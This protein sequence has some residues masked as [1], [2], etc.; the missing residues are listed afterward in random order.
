MTGSGSGVA[1]WKGVRLLVLMLVP[2]VLIGVFLASRVAPGPNGG[3]GLGRSG[4]IGARFLFSIGEGL[5][6][7]LAVALSPGAVYV[8]D[9]GHGSIKVF[10][11][12]GAYLRDV[13]IQ[14]EGKDTLPPYPVGL[15]VDAA[16]KL[17]VSDLNGA[18]ILR[19]SLVEGKSEVFLRRGES[20]PLV[21]PVGVLY[22]GGLI[23]VNDVGLGQVLVFNE[24]GTLE[25]VFGFGK[26]TGVGYM[27]YPNFSWLDK[28]G[29]LYV[30]DSN[31]NRLQAFLP[32]GGAKGV[33]GSRLNVPRGIAGDGRGRLHIVNALEHDVA[34]VSSAGALLFRYGAPGSAP[35]EFGFPNGIGI[36]G[37]RAYVADKLN[38]RVAV[39]A[40]EP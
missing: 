24:H 12:D 20:S 13:P 38:N 34:V 17:Y 26:G 18:R 2:A 27:S 1:Y 37:E 30:A 14:P 8:A 11:S 33:I 19:L 39:W 21:S 16:G 36:D 31:N 35:G 3:P 40:L 6:T 22:R 10:T 32:G 28:D 4:A 15:A 9:S 25:R 5:L 23:Y 7:P 29:T